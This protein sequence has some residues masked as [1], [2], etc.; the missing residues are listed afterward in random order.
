MPKAETIRSMFN[1][2]SEKYDLLNNILSM[3]LHW[4]WKRKVVELALQYKPKT[5]LDVAS[6]TGDI[7]E[8]VSKKD[9]N[10]KC[11]GS[12]I[13]E[14][15]LSIAQRK[16]PFYQFSVD[17][18]TNSSFKDKSFDV[19]CISFGIRN[20]SSIEKAI[21]ELR[22][23]ST[24]SVIILEFGQPTFPPF[25]LLYFSIMTYFIP[26]IGRFFSD[27]K[28]YKYLIESSKKFP[29]GEKFL[30]ICKNSTNFKKISS[31]PVFGGL[32][33]IYQLEV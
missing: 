12:D 19:S 30:S 3:R 32:C 8:L 21:K 15:M 16:M 1:N 5:L 13:S 18:I 27:Q 6:G 9:L 4:V 14:N 7:L 20:V 33:Y 2:I 25:R 31:T 11:H 29:S 22:R 26:L 17:D 24:K 23:I 10:I 28:S